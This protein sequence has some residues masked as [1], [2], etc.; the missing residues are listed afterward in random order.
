[1]ATNGESNGGFRGVGRTESDATH[2]RLRSDRHA[3][4]EVTCLSCGNVFYATSNIDVFEHFSETLHT[5]YFGDC[6]YC[7][8][9]VHTY[10]KQGQIVFFHNCFR[11]K[12]GDEK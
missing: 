11:W 5:H 7:R 12:C 9:K 2:I 8:G 6:L 4:E 1:M 10:K 3:K